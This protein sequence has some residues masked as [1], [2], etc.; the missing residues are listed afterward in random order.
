MAVSDWRTGVEYC[1]ADDV[2]LLAKAIR[3]GGVLNEAGEELE[4]ASH[5]H[6]AGSKIVET[7]LEPGL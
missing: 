3:G 4:G 2:Q 5:K 1:R 7:H 6:M